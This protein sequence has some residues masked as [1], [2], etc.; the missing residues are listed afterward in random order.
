MQAIRYFLISVAI[1]S[2]KKPTLLSNVLTDTLRTLTSS[3]PLIAHSVIIIDSATLSTISSSLAKP[4]P[5]NHLFVDLALI[6]LYSH[7]QSSHKAQLVT[8]L[9][10]AHPQSATLA[11]GDG[12]NGISII[13][14]VDIGIGITAA[15]DGLQAGRTVD[16]NFYLIPLPSKA[17]SRSWE[18]ESCSHVQ[19]VLGTFQKEMIFYMTQALWQIRGVDRQKS[20]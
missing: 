3:D 16:H 11:I 14:E 20:I 17:T 4:S 1:L 7:L 18:M 19:V 9:R 12:S 15:K 2:E 10:Q 5:F 8:L 6:S 13:R